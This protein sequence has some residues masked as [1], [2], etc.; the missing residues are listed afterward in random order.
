MR[1]QTK[2]IICCVKSNKKIIIIL[3]MVTMWATC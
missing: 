3:G 2:R 1:G